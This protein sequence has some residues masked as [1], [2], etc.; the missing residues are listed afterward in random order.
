MLRRAFIVS[1]LLVPMCHAAPSFAGMQ[2]DLASCT[3]AKGR[4]S[5]AACTRVMNSGRLPREQFYIGHFNRGSSY[6]RAGDFQEALADFKKVVDLKPRFARGYHARALAYEDLG[7]RDQALADLDQ[8]IKLDRKDWSVYYTRAAFRRVDGDFDAALQDLK[9]AAD[10]KPEMSQIGLHR[11]L[12][13]ADK[14]AVAVARAEINKIIANGNGNA[15]AYYARAEVAFAEQ[16]YDAAEED[17]DRVLKLKPDYGAAQLLMGRILAA[18]GDTKGAKARYRQA[19]DAPVPILESRSVNRLAQ[20][21]LDELDGGQSTT[22]LKPVARAA[23]DTETSKVVYKKEM[24]SGE[25]RL[26]LPTTGLTVSAPC[27]E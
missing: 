14:G 11:A 23:D 18:R 8:A 1:A 9:T 22:A 24:G 21:R 4:G 26:Y 27:N 5:A 7:K 15:S 6:R 13:L 19:L 16:R 20:A 3:A 12:I 17:L 2:Q 25:C 10:L